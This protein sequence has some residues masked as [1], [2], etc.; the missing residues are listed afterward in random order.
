LCRFIQ[1]NRY[2]L[3]KQE[4]LFR[5]N[6]IY[7]HRVLSVGCISYLYFSQAGGNNNNNDNYDDENNNNNN[8]LDFSVV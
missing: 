8:T 6:K 4:Q 5:K 3:D 7:P 1:Q 2:E